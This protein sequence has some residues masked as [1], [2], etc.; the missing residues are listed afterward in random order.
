[1]TVE[2]MRRNLK[3]G[4]WKHQYRTERKSVW[5]VMRATK[6]LG[7]SDSKLQAYLDA[8]TMIEKKINESETVWA[9]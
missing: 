5:F 2:I 1:M 4:V 6:L 9:I 7:F 8:Q 3:R